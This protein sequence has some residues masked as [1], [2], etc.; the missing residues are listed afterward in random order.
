MAATQRAAAADSLL[1]ILNRE[2][3]GVRVSAHIPAYSANHQ[4]AVIR[5][6]MARDYVVGLW[7]GIRLIADPY[8]NADQGEVK[9]NAIQLYAQS[10]LRTDGFGRRR[11]RTS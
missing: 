3:G 7:E 11:F 4:E 2:T 8:S 6:G 5:K 9:I 10:V 1:T